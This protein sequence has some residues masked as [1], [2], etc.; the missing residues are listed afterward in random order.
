MSNL[1]Q[2]SDFDFNEKT[3]KTCHIIE[4]NLVFLN[5]A[6]FVFDTE[7]LHGIEIFRSNHANNKGSFIDD[8]LCELY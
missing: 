5:K 4:N 7:L 1:Q 8:R 3:M 6:W 2:S